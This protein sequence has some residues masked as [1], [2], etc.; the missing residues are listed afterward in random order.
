MHFAVSR[1][2]A[3]K[4]MAELDRAVAG[5]EGRADELGRRVDDQKVRIAQLE[6]SLEDTQAELTKAKT[7]AVSKPGIPSTWSGPKGGPAG[8]GPKPKDPNN[9]PPCNKF[10]PLCGHIDTR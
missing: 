6:K 5:A 3:D 4:R 1:P 7:V 8:P 9:G 10:D 2:A